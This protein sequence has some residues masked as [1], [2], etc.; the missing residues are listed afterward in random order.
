MSFNYRKGGTWQTPTVKRRK[1]GQWVA[2]AATAGDMPGET[3][4]QSPMDSESELDR[5][6]IHTNSSYFGIASDPSGENRNVTS[7]YSS[8][9]SLGGGEVLWGPNEDLDAENTGENDPDAVYSRY[10]FYFPENGM[11]Y[12]P[13]ESSHGAKI[14]GVAGLYDSGVA[15][16]GTQADGRNWSARMYIRPTEHSTSNSTFDLY[17]YLY[18]PDLSGDYGVL[19]QCDGAYDFGTWHEITTYV[20]MNTPGENDGILRGWVNG[21]EV[22]NRE[23]FRFRDT[24]NPQVG[25]TRAYA[26]YTYW[27]GDWGSP[28]DQYMYFKDFTLNDAT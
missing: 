18:H 2:T 5:F 9:D 10:H 27:G 26:A 3:I 28:Q 4:F 12:D 14:P 21:T 11:I 8:Q 17:Y 25:V 20:Q 24:D 13:N 23:D 1:G 7:L 15:K 19:D 22:Y 6:H 16:G